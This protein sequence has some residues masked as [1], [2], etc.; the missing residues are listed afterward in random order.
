MKIIDPYHLDE[1]VFRLLDKDWML[2]TAGGKEEF[3]T[4]TASWGGF[5]ILWNK[6]VSFIFVRPTRHTY[7]FTEKFDRFSLCFFDKRYRKALNY[8]GSHSGR[9]VD[10]VQATGLS[11]DVTE[12]GVVFFKESRLILECRKLYLHDLDPQL[13]LDESIIRNYPKEDYHRM[14]IGQIENSW[15]ND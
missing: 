7:L 9:D 14:Y 13:F 10:K 15:Y 1:S 11:P 2:I 3:N 8:C 4:M 12:N 5:G 6:P